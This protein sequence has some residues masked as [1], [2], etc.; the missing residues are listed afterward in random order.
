QSFGAIDEKPYGLQS[1]VLVVADKL[2]GGA[3]NHFTV[4]AGDQVVLVP[5]DDVA[6]LCGT[7]GEHLPLRRLDRNSESIDCPA[8]ARPGGRGDHHSI[9]VN[10]LVTDSDGGDLTGV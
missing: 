5:G 10:P 1:H 3:D 2:D 4:F 9:G 7:N 6:E 8:L